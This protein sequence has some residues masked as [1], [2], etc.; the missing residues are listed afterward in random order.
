MRIPPSNP[1]EVPYGA[2]RRRRRRHLVV[3]QAV[4]LQREDLHLAW[5]GVRVVVT[6]VGQGVP[7][8]RRE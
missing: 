5:S 7:V 3:S 1:V 4:A 6:V 8:V 2:G